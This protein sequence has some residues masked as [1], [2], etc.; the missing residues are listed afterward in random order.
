MARDLSAARPN[1][2]GLPEELSGANEQR[3]IA[4]DA[5]CRSRR[6]ARRD[7]V[8]EVSRYGYA[9]GFGPLVRRAFSASGMEKPRH[10]NDADAPR[11]R[12]GSPIESA[13][14]LSLDAFSRTALPQT[15]LAGRRTERLLRQGS[16]CDAGRSQSAIATARQAEV[17]NSCS[18]RA[19]SRTREARMLPRRGTRSRRSE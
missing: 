10:G 14:T 12:R 9:A 19:P 8:T 7:G 1:F 16:G 18:A 13:A 5:C 11:H 2:G 4:A 17:R 6:R 3:S 15:W